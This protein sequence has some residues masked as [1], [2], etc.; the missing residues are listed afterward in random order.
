MQGDDLFSYRFT[1]DVLEMIMDKSLTLFQYFT[2]LH[3]ILK[4]RMHFES[5]R[6]I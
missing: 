1:P 2:Y 5:T 4:K 3:P 6:N